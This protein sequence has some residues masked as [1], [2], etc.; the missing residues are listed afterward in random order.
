MKW[1]VAI[2]VFL[3]L[4]V[5]TANA[6]PTI[7]TITGTVTNPDGSAAAGVLVQAKNVENGVV[8]DAMTS[9]SGQYTLNVPAGTYDLIVPAVAAKFDRYEQKNI[10]VTAA[11]FH[12]ADI[13]LRRGN[14]AQAGPFRNPAP[15]RNEGLAAQSGR[16]SARYPAHPGV[17]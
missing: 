3:F 12:Y 6:Q 9:G 14:G 10:A 5:S 7:G 2:S 8:S 16:A 17:G 13:R 11:Q 1:P 4:F 15:T